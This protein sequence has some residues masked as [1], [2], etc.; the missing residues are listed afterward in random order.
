MRGDEAPK[1]N[2]PI[3]KRYDTSACGV[4]EGV[5]RGLWRERKYPI[6]LSRLKSLD[7]IQD[8]APPHAKALGVLKTRATALLMNVP[9]GKYLRV[10][11]PSKTLAGWPCV[12]WR[13]PA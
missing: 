7:A 6:I 2:E 4:P 10:P 13:T 9:K 1:Q 12:R 3:I 8:T 11:P 5:P